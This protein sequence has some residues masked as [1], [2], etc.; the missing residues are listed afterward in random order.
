MKSVFC[1]AIESRKF[2]EFEMVLQHKSKPHIIRNWKGGWV[3]GVFRTCK[4]S[5]CWVAFLISFWYSWS[6]EELVRHANKYGSHAGFYRNVLISGHLKS[7]LNMFCLSMHHMASWDK[8]F[9][10]LRQLLLPEAFN[11]FLCSRVFDKASF[12][13]WEMK[14]ML[15]NNECSSYYGRVGDF[16]M[17]VWNQ[18]KEIFH[19]GGSACVVGQTNPTPECAAY[20]TECSGDWVWL[21]YHHKQMRPAN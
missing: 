9:E 18:I 14:G 17:S 21:N 3:W 2:K 5:T 7:Q 6:F 12:C 20:G 4:R 16:L 10:H 15:A 11:T 13:L 19:G 8:V 1:K